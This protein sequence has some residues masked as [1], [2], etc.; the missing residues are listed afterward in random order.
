MTNWAAA[1]VKMSND[2]VVEAKT[3]PCSKGWVL[4]VRWTSLIPGDVNRSHPGRGEAT[5]HALAAW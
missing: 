4:G 1:F 5:H 3:P 2:S